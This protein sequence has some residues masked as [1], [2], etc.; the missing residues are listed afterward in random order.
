VKIQAKTVEE[1]PCTCSSALGLGAG[2]AAGIDLEG[3]ALILN[4]PKGILAMTL[5]PVGHAKP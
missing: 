3:V 4:L 5:L 2:T 1:H